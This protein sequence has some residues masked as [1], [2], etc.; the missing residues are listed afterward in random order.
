MGYKMNHRFLVKLLNGT[1]VGIL[2]YSI[3]IDKFTFE[4]DKDYQGLTYSDINVNNGRVFEQETM[5]NIFNVEKS[6]NRT[7]LETRYNLKDK[8]ENEIQLFIKERQAINKTKTPNGFY[9]EKL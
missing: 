9:F 4:Y 5:F 6:W 2:S 7:R 1:T 3:Q 8:S